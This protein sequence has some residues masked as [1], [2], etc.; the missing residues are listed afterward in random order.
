MLYD[1]RDTPAELFRRLRAATETAEALGV[2]LSLQPIRYIAPGQRTRNSLAPYGNAQGAWN[3]EA[4]LSLHRMLSGRPLRTPE[5]VTERLGASEEL[6]LRA[7]H[8]R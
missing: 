7:L 4:L 1:F 6:F 8:A 2:S 3:A 5:D